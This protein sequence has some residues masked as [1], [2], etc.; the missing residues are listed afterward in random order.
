[1]MS[2]KQPSS[3]SA[4]AVRN[5]PFQARYEFDLGAHMLPNCFYATA[6]LLSSRKCYTP[7]NADQAHCLP[8]IFVG[9][10]G[11]HSVGFS[12]TSLDEEFHHAR[13]FENRLVSELR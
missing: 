11:T 10:G 9:W 7:V 6:S 8:R 4:S 2:Y 12:D 3:A 1:M 5:S 13:M